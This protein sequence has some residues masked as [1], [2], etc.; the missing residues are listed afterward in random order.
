MMKIKRPVEKEEE[1]QT[2][3]TH[4]DTIE[5]RETTIGKRCACI[6]IFIACVCDMPKRNFPNFSF[7]VSFYC[8]FCSASSSN[9]YYSCTDKKPKDSLSKQKKK[10]QE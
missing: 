3:Y 10:R 2:T 4:T 6:L 1:K 9:I 7:F 5:N 8:C